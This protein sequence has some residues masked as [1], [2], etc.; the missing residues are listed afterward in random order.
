M[1][2]EMSVPI[3]LSIIVEWENVLLS[4]DERCFLMLRK[5]SRQLGGI[6]RRA[7]VIVLFNPDQM[8]RAGIETVLQ[9]HFLLE[10]INDSVNLRLEEALGRHY[11]EL[12][13]EGAARARGQIV[14]FID[15][16]AVPEDNWLKEISQPFFDHPEICVVAG[17]TYL[18]HETL[19]EKAFTLGWFFPLRN[20]ENAIHSNS[21]GFFA[22][23]VAFRRDLF[24]KYPFPDLPAGLCRGACS[25]LAQTLV[26]SGI[27]I[28]TNTAARS[29]HP[30]P[31]DLR[32][33]VNRALGEGRNNV[34][35]HTGTGRNLFL[36]LGR[37]FLWYMKRV[38]SAGR[39][40]I[41]ERQR[42]NLP[43]WQTPA[44]FS[45]M[46]C[47]YSLSICGSCATVLF[48]RYGRKHW[49]I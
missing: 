8:D 14:I 2:I 49:Q 25:Q 44:A 4:E 22:N 1:Q 26:S 21:K 47:F 31:T 20:P 18:S 19:F 38:V 23:S 27:S 10:D 13:N 17:H 39:R 7:E 37:S 45:I 33:Y 11:Y 29:S 3:D 36:S 16:D 48:P 34:L 43:F 46:L 40:M 5:L 24:L 30:P 12:K 32:Q 35:L 6:N 9:K 28:W 41:N 42:V 15:T